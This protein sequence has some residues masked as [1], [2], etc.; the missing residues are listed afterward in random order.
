MSTAESSVTDD[1]KLAINQELIWLGQQLQPTEPLFEVPY[2]YTIRGEL[3]P[4][5]F[6]AA[7]NDLVR[8]TE[9]LRVVAQDDRW[10]RPHLANEVEF[11][12]ENVD[13]SEARDRDLAAK[14][15]I[16]ER[17]K[18]PFKPT[19]SLCHATLVRRDQN[20]WLLFLKLH[21]ALTDALCG[22]ALLK[23]LAAYYKARREGSSTP[24]SSP[25]QRNVESDSGD[26]RWWSDRSSTR[27][28]TCFYRAS[29]VAGSTRHTRVTHQSADLS[30]T[31][32]RLAS[33][34]PFQQIT[35]ALSH[36]NVLATAMASWLYRLSP[37][38]S[39]LIG[40]TTHGRSTPQSRDAIG[41]FMQLLP[42]RVNVRAEDSFADISRSVAA[43]SMGFLK[44]A[45]P[46]SMSAASQ[47]A[48]DVV[49]NLIDLEVDDFCGMP[50]TM[51][52][53]HNGYGE[54]E[55]KLCISAYQRESGWHLLFDFND[56]AF[57]ASERIR[58]IDSFNATIRSMAER[59]N[60]SMSELTFLTEPERLRLVDLD[61]SKTA[62]AEF[63][64]GDSIWERFRGV[65]SEH[66]SQVAITCGTGDRSY[67]ELR[68]LAESL[69][70]RI[71]QAKLGSLVPILCRRDGRAVAAML[72]VLASG[73]CFL[74]IDRDLPDSRVQTLLEESGSTKLLDAT[75]ESVP[76]R[77]SNIIS[78]A[79]CPL[80]QG[81]CYV[82]F[83]SGST[84]VPSGVVVADHSLLNLLADFERL[85]PLET[86][87]RVGWW[88]N[89]GFDVAIYE[90]FSAILF[91]RSLHIPSEAIRSDASMMVDWI[92]SQ[93]IASVYLPPYFL[94]RLE[95]RVAETRGSTLRRLL[96]GVEPI[97]QSLLATIAVHARKLSLIN[98]YGPTEA[99]VCATLER[100]DPA[101]KTPG[102][103]SIGRPVAG[104]RL[105]IVDRNG[106][107]VPPGVRGELWI[108]GAGLAKGYLGDP[109]KTRDR[110]VEREGVVW[111]RSG[112]QVRLREDGK[113]QF[114]G[115]VDEQLKV[116]GV[117]IEPGE[118]A[119]CIRS[120]DGVSECIVLPMMRDEKAVGL[121][122]FV[123]RL[124]E[125]NESAL[126]SELRERL[127][128][129]MV[130][131]RIV[132]LDRLPRTI[133]GK[134]DR[135]R[136]DSSVLEETERAPV[137]QTLS[138]ARTPIEF[139]L[140]EL[141]KETLVRDKVDV[142]DDFFWLGGS[143]LDAMTVA[144]RA[145][146]LGLRFTIQDLFRYP[147]IREFADWLDSGEP[148][149]KEVERVVAPPTMT[150]RQRTLWYLQQARPN[151]FTYHFQLRS[152]TDG[153]L[154]AHRVQ[155]CLDDLS[156]RHPMLRTTV[157]AHAGAPELR[158]HREPLV[159]LQRSKEIDDEPIAEEGRR[160]FDL[161]KDP[162]WRVWM[163]EQTGGDEL[164]WTFHHIA[165]DEASIGVLIR[166]FSSL[167][168]G[169]ALPTPDH[170]PPEAVSK[171][172]TTRW[173]H[174]RLSQAD[175]GISLPTDHPDND[176]DPGTLRRFSI[177]SDVS[178]L[179]R[180]LASQNRVSV[181]S[182]LLSA[183]GALLSKYSA[184]KR[185]TIGLPIS[186]RG[187]SQAIG[188]H[189]DGLPMVIE[190]EPK[191]S[192]SDFAKGVHA[193]F[194]EMLQ[195]SDV[196]AELLQREYGSLFNVMFV[197]Q[198]TL[199]ATKLS[200]TIELVPRIN[201]LGGSKFDWTLFVS[202]EGE[203]IE[204]SME[205]RNQRFEPSTIEHFVRHWQTLL[206]KVT[207]APETSLGELDVRVEQDKEAARCL[208]GVV[209]EPIRV[210]D[211][212]VS[213]QIERAATTDAASVA[214]RTAKRSLTYQALDHNAGG[215]A[216]TLVDF[217]VRESEP[218]VIACERSASMIPA[219]LGVLK[220]NAAYV[221]I[222]PNL[223]P[224]RFEERVQHVGARFIVSH[225]QHA[226]RFA[227]S[228]ATAIDADACFQSEFACGRS[229]ESLAYIL[230]TSGSTGVPKGVEVTRDA[231]I[232]SN[233]AR[234]TF[235][236]HPPQRFLMV[237]PIWFDSSIAGIFWTLCAGGSLV[238]P[239]EQD[240]GDVRRLADLVQ[241]HQITDTLMLPSLYELL[242]RHGDI[243]KLQ[244]LRRVI[245]AGESCSSELVEAHHRR[246]PTTRLFNEYGPTEA[247]VWATACELKPGVPVNIGKSV[248]GIETRLLDET[249]HDVPVGCVGEI[250]LGGNRLAKAYRNDANLTESCFVTRGAER[251]YRTGDL[252]RLKADGSLIY[253]GRQDQQLKVNGQRVEAAEIESAL[254]SIS[255][256]RE[257]A[258]AITAPPGRAVKED[259]A[260]LVQALGRLDESLASRLLA[261]AES[262]DDNSFDD[263]LSTADRFE[264]GDTNYQ[265][266]LQ[267]RDASL[268]ETPRERQKRW[269]LDQVLR[270]T[271]ANLQSL[272]EHA[273]RM[274]PGSDAPHLP[275]DL[276]TEQL[277]DQE[278]MEDWQTP[279]MRSMVQWV[280]ESEGDLLEIGFGRGV[281]ATAIQEAGVRS[282]TVIEMNPHSITDHF[283]PWRERYADREIHLVE[284]RWQDALDQLNEYDAVFFHA[285]PMNEAEFVD[286]VA[287]SATFA[288]HFFPVAARLL[289]P[290][291]VFTYL[292]TEIDS[293]S[294]RHQR[295]LLS[296][297]EEVH[298]KVQPLTVPEDTKDA[299]WAD[300][301]VVVRAIK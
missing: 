10:S 229:R 48:F 168:R 6:C 230:H 205:Y 249:G 268:I 256:V 42:F 210:D 118:V 126:R 283:H 232:R 239:E 278:I 290:G 207:E 228:A 176:T 23:S 127:P 156:H 7:F 14:T 61:A 186:Q 292:S 286:Y 144:D 96:V 196:D 258:V 62:P 77:D 105:R 19:E 244:S 180:D 125:L 143:S 225:G 253:L 297:F 106:C 272:H 5:T 20:C 30:E 57:D 148:P 66:E 280:T 60:Q 271:V 80:T 173:W 188:Y 140:V 22:R 32:N 115:R 153:R 108:G 267:L 190:C 37:S 138:G 245:V 226:A 116:S 259:D 193:L 282:H 31:I 212:C 291:G 44:N 170:A 25:R 123:E 75:A 59:P 47:R 221:P 121:V 87:S 54:P 294:R 58:V 82:L 161:S 79:F 21:H 70:S 202:D 222:D 24:A 214:V 129:A 43:E 287:Q 243:E 65:A 235:Y 114:L 150:P 97:E 178:R 201:D 111:Y 171:A 257:A 296:H 145:R 241:R 9:T 273:K 154:D 52:W 167:Y 18:R 112:D 137:S 163:I 104:N 94:R 34:K 63:D 164:V 227:T 1:F 56:D 27:T 136:L 209:E 149:K 146:E 2:L 12:I 246:L 185:F 28:G 93:S 250:H 179:L 275:R 215:I 231:M 261:D 238:I 45:F 147:T 53:L 255:G 204:C 234:E 100:I 90:V 206:R 233:A 289:R 236:Q 15:L 95:Q 13:V 38:D 133:N 17:L 83:T 141:W 89:I 41:L 199:P 103:A 51:E 55:R 237:S 211:D 159:K 203:S 247:T 132:L 130:P 35:P 189:I 158:L 78:P 40:T 139:T 101:D 248:A 252:A 300:S 224:E 191:S 162:A 72:G 131:S 274:V 194:G 29:P 299:W 217:G 67:G 33:T 219:I 177:P 8:D 71:D 264:H 270:E 128:R 109:A 281:A 102:P 266:T 152:S 277:A 46:G 124:H 122:A 4:E 218:V 76:I 99:T 216:K 223:P 69:A 64:L 81:A 269:L 198:K 175:L 197:P 284:G 285:F 74:P 240:L 135:D 73:R 92:A 16:A 208:K 166:E 200:D 84:G 26:G 263:A 195:H 301:M 36:L 184:S 251:F 155:Q 11:E 86:D 182:L 172:S 160:A 117:R 113:L 85:S 68:E 213:E 88:T 276:S 288:E 91:G 293:L 298:L 220:A 157:E 151:S 192:F 110:F 265:V 107:D 254:Q 120:L 262:L 242:L 165:F 3:E 183:Y 260:S 181:V 174:A 169:D 119:S 39:I 134:I 279:L 49:L 187:E 142:K 50:T 295:S 98:G